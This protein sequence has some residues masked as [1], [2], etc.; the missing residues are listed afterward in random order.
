M[1]RQQYD[2]VGKH[3]VAAPART[4]EYG[5]LGRLANGTLPV[6]EVRLPGY[7]SRHLIERLVYQ[8]DVAF[9]MDLFGGNR[10]KRKSLTVDECLQQQL[11][12]NYD[13]YLPAQALQHYS[14][15]GAALRQALHE[16]IEPL[17]TTVRQ[18]RNPDDLAARKALFFA[19]TSGG[20]HGKSLVALPAADGKV[21]WNNPVAKKEM[22][23]LLIGRVKQLNHCGS[24]KDC[25]W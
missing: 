22:P 2:A 1:T 12:E 24:L 17:L 21:H 3:S 8:N 15:A 6:P 11:I 19:L 5:L 9:R 18:A 16:Q 25:R 4:I 7:P 13:H 14:A 10:M 20:I 23:G